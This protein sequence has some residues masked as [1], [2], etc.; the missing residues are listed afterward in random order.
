MR[1]MIGKE[2]GLSVYDAS[3]LVARTLAY[4]EIGGDWRNSALVISAP[5]DYPAIWPQSPIPLNIETY[6]KEG[7]LDVDNLRGGEATY[8][9]VSSRMNNGQNIVFFGYHG[10]E[11]D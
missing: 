3:Q 7:G 1:Y 9:R 2:I 8:Q 4:D 11:N 5:S 6:L 10:S